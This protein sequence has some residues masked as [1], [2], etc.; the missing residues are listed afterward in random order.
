MPLN[1]PNMLEKALK[2]GYLYLLR[3]IVYFGT[4]IGMWMFQFYLLIPVFLLVIATDYY[5]INKNIWLLEK[6]E[7]DQLPTLVAISVSPLLFFAPYYYEVNPDVSTVGILLFSGLGIAVA[8]VL[9]HIPIQVGV[10]GKNHIVSNMVEQDVANPQLLPEETESTLVNHINTQT[11][12][13]LSQTSSFVLL[14]P[15]NESYLVSVYSSKEEFINEI[16][17]TQGSELPASRSCPYC[18]SQET[19][20]RGTNSEWKQYEPKITNPI[21]LGEVLSSTPICDECKESVST[22]LL[23][24]E[25]SPIGEEDVIAHKI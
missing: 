12:Y 25:Q 6:D 23:S 3:P 24:D 20:I 11:L 13:D 19:T 22:A 21:E 5:R 1:I 10:A 14:I 8:A 16:L 4:A 9:F 2:I 17:S 18:G 15:T 7:I